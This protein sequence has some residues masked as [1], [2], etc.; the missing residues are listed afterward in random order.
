MKKRLTGILYIALVGC[1][2]TPALLL[3]QTPG[4]SSGSI[5]YNCSGSFCGYTLPQFATQYISANAT[6][7]ADSPGVG[8][9]VA[10]SPSCWGTNVGVLN[11]TPA[12]GGTTICS[13]VAGS[14]KQ[15][16]IIKNV[17]TNPLFIT[18]QCSS[19]STAANRFY[20]ETGIAGFMISAGGQARI[21]VVAATARWA[22]Q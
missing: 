22:L 9:L 19:D 4:G 8:P 5:Q 10:Y 11:I 3:A 15:D 6:T 20:F 18:N 16:L 13:L 2:L 21:T 14:D 1:A 17:G 12:T 7:C